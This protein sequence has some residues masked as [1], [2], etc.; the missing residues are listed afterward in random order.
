MPSISTSLSIIDTAIFHTND[1]QLNGDIQRCR[2]DQA[3]LN[4]IESH[5]QTSGGLPSP[6]VTIH[7]IM[8][9]I[10]PYWH[11]PRY[12]TKVLRSGSN[13]LHNNVPI[14][15]YGHNNFEVDEL[16]AAFA[17]LV[18]KVTHQDLLA[19]SRMLPSTEKWTNF[20]QLAR[21]YGAMQTKAANQPT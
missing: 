8:D 12:R 17:I 3:A 11:E 21:K 2:V 7:T 20:L 15:R 4:E 16:L 14:V 1:F 13:L 6:L 5:Y 19:T 9:E 18:F 10:V